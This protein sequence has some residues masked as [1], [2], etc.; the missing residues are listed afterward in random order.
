MWPLW[1]GLREED[2]P[3]GLALILTSTKPTQS[4]HSLH[5][6]LLDPGKWHGHGTDPAAAAG[7]KRQRGQD[8][9]ELMYSWSGSVL[10]HEAR[11]QSGK[12]E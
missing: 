11:Q 3:H 9:T 7:E 10:E 1:R 5:P 4:Q 6:H 8:R 12:V 2:E